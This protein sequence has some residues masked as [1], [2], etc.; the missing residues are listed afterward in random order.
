MTRRLSGRVI[1]KTLAPV[2]KL[3]FSS[4]KNLITFEIDT[5]FSGSLLMPMNMLI[6]SLYLPKAQSFFSKKMAKSSV[7][8][9]EQ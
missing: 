9:L 7:V 8:L 4:F 2:L 1:A 5:G 3:K 6:F